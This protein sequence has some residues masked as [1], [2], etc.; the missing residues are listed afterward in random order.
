M[1]RYLSSCEFFL[2]FSFFLLLVS[3]YLLAVSFDGAP[4]GI[5]CDDDRSRYLK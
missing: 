5:L 1:I 3:R 2:F 4:L